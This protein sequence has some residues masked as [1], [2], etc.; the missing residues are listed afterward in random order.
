MLPIL[1]PQ[2][3]AV[4]SEGLTVGET[5]MIK[6]MTLFV[7]AFSVCAC[8]ALAQDKGKLTDPLDILKRAD[9]AAKAV[10]VARY[11][12]KSFALDE[13]GKATP[14]AQG[15]ALIEGFTGRGPEKFK[16]AGTFI[17]PGSEDKQEL[18]VGSDSE[19][20]YLIDTKAKKAYVDID[21]AVVG[22][23]GFMAFSIIMAEFVHS[24]PFSDEIKGTKHKLVGTAKV[25]NE[26]CYEVMVEYTSNGQQAHWF[27]STKDYLPRRVDR[28]FM[29]DGKLRGG[30]RLIV[31]SLK[32]DPKLSENV[33]AFK[34]PNGFE[35][36]DDFAP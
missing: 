36:V 30:S 12:A 11:E 7:V 23:R 2:A 9:S 21:P 16:V 25:G 1:Q 28:F 29:R 4:G 18:A 27:F 15:K 13:A 35:Q 10:K 19:N 8:G 22:P 17:R 33:Y 34:L 26:D 32:V 3:V 24:K 20:Y 14:V 31:T 6:K 5:I